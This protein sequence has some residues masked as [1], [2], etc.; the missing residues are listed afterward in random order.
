MSI[1][2]P[3]KFT[4]FK[5]VVIKR[6][7]ELDFCV[8]LPKNTVRARKN[9]FPMQNSNPVFRFVWQIVWGKLFRLV[10]LII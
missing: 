1:K 4:Q 2:Q 9:S 3:I 6:G 10:F 8:P 7:G 5:S